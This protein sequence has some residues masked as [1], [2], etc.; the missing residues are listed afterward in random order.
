MRNKR[1]PEE[2]QARQLKI[3]SYQLAPL[4]AFVRVGFWLSLGLIGLGLLSMLFLRF[5]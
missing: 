4:A 2:E 3:I 1:T 5:Q